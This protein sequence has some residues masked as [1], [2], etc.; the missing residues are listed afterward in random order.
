M[1]VS[2]T[3]S[4]LQS[5]CRSLVSSPLLLVP[6]WSNAV[7][8]KNVNESQLGWIPF[9]WEGWMPSDS[10]SH[11]EC[12]SIPLCS[13]RSVVEAEVTDSVDLRSSLALSLWNMPLDCVT[14]LNLVTL[15]AVETWPPEASYVRNVFNAPP[16][17]ASRMEKRWGVFSVY[18]C[19]AKYLRIV[20][21]IFFEMYALHMTVEIGS[22]SFFAFFFP[23][24]QMKFL[25][26]RDLSLGT[27]F[28]L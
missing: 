25:L 28:E 18:L 3:P 7:H 2:Y 24:N 15:D 14:T 4:E 9:V 22:F 8:Q 21:S 5:V 26:H 1:K 27:C 16:P 19:K 10:S 17:K 6:H 12:F 23:P 20:A 11:W 13:C